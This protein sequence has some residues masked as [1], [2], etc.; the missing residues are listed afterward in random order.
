MDKITC[1]AVDDERP[2]LDKVTRFISRI[3]FLELV[4]QFRDPAEA[5]AYMQINPVEL[6]FLDIQME[7]LTGIQFIEALPRRPLIILV[8]AFDKFAMKGFDLDVCDYILKPFDYERFYKASLK[9]L[10]MLRTLDREMVAEIDKKPEKSHDFIFI[11]TAYRLE[12][13]EL[14]DIYYIQGMREYLRIFTSKAKIMTL[15]S[16]SELESILPAERF[17]RVHKSWMVALDKIENIERKR[18][19]ILGEYIPISNSRYDSFI[20]LLKEQNRIHLKQR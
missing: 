17:V 19:R 16:F 14:N 20:D 13:V 2:A 5:M 11:K 9:A 15:Q 8:T 4:N 10:K 1:I 3:P 18:I 12:K 7:N 6:V